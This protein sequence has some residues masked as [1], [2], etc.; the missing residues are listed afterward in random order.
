MNKDFLG[1]LMP[2][3]ILA[4]AIALFLGFLYI[5][6]YVVIIG[7]VISGLAWLYTGIKTLLNGNQPNHRPSKHKGII[8]DHDN[9]K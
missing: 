4:G 3:F 7:L 6:F 5:M 9:I 8:I 2:F 1:S